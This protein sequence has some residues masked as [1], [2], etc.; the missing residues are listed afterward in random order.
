MKKM[1]KQ[2]LQKR[3]A[4]LKKM[5]HADVVRREVM[6]FRLEPESIEKLY[7]I[8]VKKRKPIGTIIREWINERIEAELIDPGTT[9]TRAK[10][11]SYRDLRTPLEEIKERIFV[12]ETIA[13][14]LENSKN[15]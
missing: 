8:A 4:E 6:Q 11:L 14:K 5:V 1:S 10:S 7:K 12:C 3:K 9:K 15:K 2:E 13:N